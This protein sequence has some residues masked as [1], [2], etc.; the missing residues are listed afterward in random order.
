MIQL[1]LARPQ[2][3]LTVNPVLREEPFSRPKERAACPRDLLAGQCRHRDYG[4]TA[5][6]S[7]PSPRLVS[8]RKGDFL[9]DLLR[10]PGRRPRERMVRRVT[11]GRDI[12]LMPASHQ[13]RFV[14]S[15]RV[16]CA[17]TGRDASL[18][19]AAFANLCGVAL[20]CHLDVPVLIGDCCVVFGLGIIGRFAADSQDAPRDD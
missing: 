3:G 5:V 14:V 11:R 9:P 7:H 12:L 4:L 10:L 15:S 6:R 17:G 8:H 1:H 16:C 18:E 2:S 13:D 19:A 20:N